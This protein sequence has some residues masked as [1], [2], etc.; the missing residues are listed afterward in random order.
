MKKYV[1][2]AATWLVL[3]VVLVASTLAQG[4]APGAATAAETALG[5][6]F[7][8]Q[9]KL[10]ANGEQVTDDCGMAFRLYDA[11]DGGSQVGDAITTTVAVNAGLFTAS[12]DFG[13]D[14]FDGDARWLG[15]RVKC[16][17]DATYADLGR[18]ALTAT[19]YALYARST[20][21]LQGR[22][23][24]AASPALNQVLKWN[25]SA[26]APA[27]ESGAAGGNWSLTGNSATVPGTHFLG[28]TDGVSLTLAVSG[29]AALR[30]EPNGTSPNLVGGHSSNQA[31]GVVGATV[32]G[33]GTGDAPNQVTASFGTV[34]GG[35]GNQASGNR[36]TVGGGQD[37]AADGIVA[38]VSGGW[39]NNA[40]GMFTT[41]GGGWNNT[42]AKSR[43]TVS[44]GA[45]NTASGEGAIV[46]GGAANV[47]TA[48]FGT[49]AGGEHISVTGDYAAVAGGSWITVT[50]DYAAVGG[51]YN[52]A[53]NGYS[54]ATIGGGYYNTA[55][56]YGATV[57]GGQNNVASNDF[58][59]VD[60]GYSNAASGDSA[61]V[62]GGLGNAAS[63]GG[64]TV[65]GGVYNTASDSYA[66]VSGGYGNTASFDYATV[67]GG[68]DNT[69][70]GGGA[71]VGGGYYNTANGDSAAV[72]GGFNNAT[73]GHYATISGGYDNE[74]SDYY[75][76]V[77]GGHYNTASSDSATVGGGYYNTASYDYATV[78]GG[79]GNTASGY[80]ATVPGGAGNIASGDY[81][82]A[83]GTY[84]QADDEG[85]FVWADSTVA[86]IFAP[87]VDTFSVRASGGVWFG[88][89]SSPSI[90]AGRFI[91]TSTGGYLSTG[92]AWTDSSDRA[93]KENFAPVDGQEVLARLADVPI[94]TWNYR[95]QDASVRHIGP[96]AQDFYAAFG[97][98]EDERHIA[99]LDA[100]GVALAAI[101]ELYAQNQS[102]G[103][104]IEALQRQ[105]ADLEARLSAL[106]AASAAQSGV[107]DVGNGGW[108][109]GLAV[110][111]LGLGAVWGARRA[112]RDGRAGRPEE[113]ER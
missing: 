90:P 51:G 106:E 21:A 11:S 105:N 78:G 24:T 36:A 76:T 34:G 97:L 101:Q 33:G 26:W 70:S 75:A 45:S 57:G 77:A 4:P 53:A 17:G 95:A 88:T 98:G 12:L 87:G 79:Y 99:A 93:R 43:A 56:G 91:N 13:G 7:T 66:T 69:A 92:G 67:G 6:A 18:Q 2:G 58:A 74:A 19:P 54:Y 5:T 8:Y 9:G 49:V 25:G 15:I 48:T 82:F 38:T 16:G 109:P 81:S 94:T 32:G 86:N 14:A 47:V 46:G 28:T 1:W 103:A 41:V 29:T 84:A 52:N 108:M 30:L 89:D 60:G 39:N 20:G 27:D 40:D 71:T 64:A 31:A 83:A 42:A 65:G 10:Q 37:N 80:Y 107:L 85:A 62:G 63:G 61:T 22:P 50:G 112:P 44:G 102:Q 96:T 35:S 55:S 104:Q 100:N 3:M 59:S 23:V 113:G 111:L 73:S 72:G 110:L 68:Y